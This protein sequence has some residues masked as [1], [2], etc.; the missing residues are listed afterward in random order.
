MCW[1]KTSHFCFHC[2]YNIFPLLSQL[3]T[4]TLKCFHCCSYFIDHVRF[5]YM[6]AT[7]SWLLLVLGYTHTSESVVGVNSLDIVWSVMVIDF[8][9]LLTIVLYRSWVGV[10]FV[11][12]MWNEVLLWFVVFVQSISRSAW[13]L[14]NYS[15]DIIIHY[16]LGRCY[17][18][19]SVAAAIGRL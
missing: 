11:N 10:S 13:I 1:A 12:D 9:M 18:L 3:S 6:E 8:C 5:S 16:I 15:I 19:Y 2:S 4:A 17:F 14:F 7:S